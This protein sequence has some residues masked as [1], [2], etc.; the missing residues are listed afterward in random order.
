MGGRR[1]RLDHNPAARPL[2]CNGRYGKSGAD[3]HRRRGE[4]VCRRCAN[5][6]N[7]YAR[8]VRRKAIKPR[9]LKPCGTNAAAERHRAK[10]EELCLP[11]KVAIGERVQQYR[12][13]QKVMDVH[14]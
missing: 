2:G 7:H 14:Q 5:S 12:D 9:A 3:G 13:K 10:G 6:A 8:E 11:C 1:W 4:K